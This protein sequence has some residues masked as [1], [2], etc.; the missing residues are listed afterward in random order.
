MALPRSNTYEWGL[1]WVLRAMRWGYMCVPNFPA[2][3]SLPARAQGARLLCL[4]FNS[5]TQAQI[6]DATLARLAKLAHLPLSD[7]N[8]EQYKVRAR[9][10]ACLLPLGALA[11]ACC[12]CAHT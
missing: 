7:D 9:G 12:V 5:L 2:R 8:I 1:P 6:D 11:G 4:F 10:F 3:R